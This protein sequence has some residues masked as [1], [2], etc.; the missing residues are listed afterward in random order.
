MLAGHL[1]APPDQYVWWAL[2]T[3][4]PVLH[5]PTGE[6]WDGLEVGARGLQA[7]LAERDPSAYGRCGRGWDQLAGVDTRLLPG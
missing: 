5:A 4:A 2:R 7:L 3:F 1:G 6:V